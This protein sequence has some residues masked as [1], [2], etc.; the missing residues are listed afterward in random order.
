M[1]VDIKSQLIYYS[2]KLQQKNFV[3]GPGGNTSCKIEDRIAIKPSGLEFEELKISDLV[4]IDLSS[5]NPSLL[6]HKFRPSSEYLMH[7][8]IY[9]MRPEISCIIHAHPPYVIGLTA[10]DIEIKHLFPDGVVYL[11]EKIPLID[12]CTPCTTKLAELV[13]TNIKHHHVLILKNHGAIT[14]GEN[15]KSAYLRMELLENLAYIQW[16]ALNLKGNLNQINFLSKE[17]IEEILNLES[18]KYRQDIL[19]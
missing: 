16:I 11:G 13:Q 10:C 8:K 4:E 19:K 15:V 14:I 2:K 17:N 6:P 12:Y 7:V 18:E 3:I 9:Q 1:R 5:E